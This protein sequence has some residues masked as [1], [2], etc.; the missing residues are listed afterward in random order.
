MLSKN[1]PPPGG[2]VFSRDGAAAICV[3]PTAD[4]SLDAGSTS[5]LQS[6]GQWMD[7]NSAGIYG[8]RA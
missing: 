1:G 6:I 5:M 8:S 2:G 7:V 3:S 4:G